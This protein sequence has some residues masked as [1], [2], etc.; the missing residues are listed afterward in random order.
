MQD[1]AKNGSS[2]L[3]TCVMEYL[4]KNLRINEAI[5]FLEPFASEDPTLVSLIC[6]AI[7]SVDKMKESIILLAQKIKEYPMLVTLLLK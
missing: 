6:D 7:M 3:I 5:E 1:R 2:F 4:I